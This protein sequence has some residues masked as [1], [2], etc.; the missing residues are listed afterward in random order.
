MS[1]L[2]VR[3]NEVASNLSR[4]DHSNINFKETTYRQV[5]LLEFAF[6][7]IRKN[8]LSDVVI[9]FR[10]VSL[11]FLLYSGLTNPLFLKMKYTNIKF[12]NK[13]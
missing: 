10:Q 7:V 8:S 1:I 3:G 6:P 5:R 13:K 9:Q 12:I 4:K 2:D 11:K